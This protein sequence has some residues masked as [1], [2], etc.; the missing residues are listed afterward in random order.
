[1]NDSHERCQAVR[2]GP[3]STD[4]H[5]DIVITDTSVENYPILELLGVSI[6]GQMNFKEQ[7]GEVTKKASK[8]VGVLLRLRNIIPQSAKLKIYKTATLPLLTYCHVVWHFCAASD[9]R[10]LERLQEKAL[11]AVYRSKTVTYDTLLKMANLSTLCNRRLQD[12]AHLMYKVKHH[13]CPK[14]I[15][16]LFS[17][18]SS[19]YALRNADFIV[20]RFNTVNFGKHSIRYLGPVLWSKLS[21]DRTHH[22]FL[23]IE[24]D[25]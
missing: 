4:R 18:N 3:K 10:K 12:V 11:Q 24:L 19:G 13:L 17:L 1:M 8:Q 7:I 15:S 21:M 20:P 25:E 5:I 22:K 6:D 9:A 14:Y 16:D 23:K 2:F